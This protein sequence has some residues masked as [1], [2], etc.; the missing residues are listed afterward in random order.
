[1]VPGKTVWRLSKHV[2]IGQADRKMFF[3]S[4][5]M[6]T[7]VTRLLTDSLTLR[8]GL[9]PTDLLPGEALLPQRSFCL[10]LFQ[11]LFD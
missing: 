10:R 11:E 3:D 9:D 6:A 2:Q 8:R 4:G 7:K 5:P 1:M